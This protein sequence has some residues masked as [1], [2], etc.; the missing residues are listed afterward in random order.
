VLKFNLLVA[1]FQFKQFLGAS[2]RPRLQ[3]EKRTVKEPINQLAQTSQ[4]LSIFGGAKPREDPGDEVEYVNI[5]F[6]F[7]KKFL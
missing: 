5:F 3:L 1:I 7:R 6:F 2:D 4:S